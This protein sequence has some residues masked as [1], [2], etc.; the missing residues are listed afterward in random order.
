MK[1][2]QRLHFHRL[3]RKVCSVGLALVSYSSFQ[4]SSH[5]QEAIEVEEGFFEESPAQSEVF[6]EEALP[7]PQ[8]ERP[9]DF[10]SSSQ[11]I[12]S[13]PA[14]SPK[15]EFV[16][17]TQTEPLPQ[18]S[19]EPKPIETPLARPVEKKIKHPLMDKGL[20]RIKADGTYLFDKEPSP[21]K[22]GIS[23]RFGLYEPLNLE[24]PK[25]GESF[26]A[27]YGGNTNAMILIDYEWQFWKMALGKWAFKFGSGI[28]LA[29]GNGRFANNFDENLNLTPKE[30]FTFLALPNSLGL[31]YRMQWSDYQ[32][33]VPYGSGGLMG[34]TF[35][36]IRDDGDGP[37]FGFSP[38]AF[39][40]GG[41]ALNLTGLSRHSARLLD[42]EYGIN[43]AFL[44]GEFKNIFT[45][46]GDFDFSAAFINFGFLLEY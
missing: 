1:I 30:V 43:G 40:S 4:V 20:R 18:I 44:V 33:F 27:N 26:E 13:S 16:D 35:A 7:L 45:L 14:D 9:G 17:E 36:E 15:F 5:A 10:D 2:S 46:G 22:H 28:F 8:V 39:A 11:P 31:S 25:N 37:K 3:G 24:N 19:R 21:Q 32:L 38:A 23:V 34:F 12:I 6:N 41:L 42:Y 29:S